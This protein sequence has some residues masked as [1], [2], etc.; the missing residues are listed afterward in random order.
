MVAVL[1]HYCNQ[2]LCCD[3]LRCGELRMRSGQLWTHPSTC[4]HFSPLYSTLG[5]SI[6]EL[7]CAL[8]ARSPFKVKT[9]LLGLQFCRFVLSS[10]VTSNILINNVFTTVCY[11]YCA[12]VLRRQRCNIALR[13]SEGRAWYQCSTIEVASKGRQSVKRIILHCTQL[14]ALFS[15]FI[16]GLE[17]KLEWVYLNKK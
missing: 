14:F 2:L 9:V 10:H 12:H 11:H 3:K 1:L 13:H 6:S 7:P 16:M 5:F 17:M 15:A 8:P 4:C